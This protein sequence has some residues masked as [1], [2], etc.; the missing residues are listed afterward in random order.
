MPLG[1]VTSYSTDCGM[2][3]RLEAFTVTTCPSADTSMRSR[4]ECS[5]CS[6]TSLRSQAR[7]AISPPKLLISSRLPGRTAKV[8]SVCCRAA[9]AARARVGTNI[10]LLLDPLRDAARLAQQLDFAPHRFGEMVIQVRV[11]GILRQ[12]PAR[13]RDGRVDRRETVLEHPDGQAV[14]PPG[15]LA[16]VQRALQL[17]DGAVVRRIDRAHP[18]HAA[19]PGLRDELAAARRGGAAQGEPRATRREH[20]QRDPRGEQLRHGEREPA[21]AR[22]DGDDPDPPGDGGPEVGPGGPVLERSGAGDDLPELVQGRAALGAIR[23]VRGER[24]ALGGG[25]RLVQV[26]RQTGSPVV[27]H[28]A[29][30]PFFN[31][32]ASAAPCARGAAAISTSR[33]RCPAASRSPR[34]GTPRRRA[35]GTPAWRRRGG[36][37]SPARSPRPSPACPSVRRARRAR[38]GRSPV[39]RAPGPAPCGGRGPGSRRA[40]AATFRTPPHRGTSPA[41]ATRGR[42]RPASGH[43]PDPRPSCAGTDCESGPDESGTAARTHARRRSPRGRRPLLPTRPPPM[44]DP[45]AV[46]PPRGSCTRLDRWPR[47]KVVKDLDPDALQ[48]AEIIGLVGV[49]VAVVD[50]RWNAPRH[51]LQQNRHFNYNRNCDGQRYVV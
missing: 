41:S 31:P 24:L 12:R 22:R 10:S 32:G 25:Q 4:L 40:G 49:L 8:V 26:L 34:A 44:L 11:A 15:A 3:R 21:A 46:S 17:G 16:L 13:L 36:G 35:A 20:G 37:R 23:Q 28:R 27:A 30:P 33:R 5:A 29:T 47:S 18:P 19:G 50:P 39:A 9:R 2:P 43:P 42:T 38:P 1:T 51:Q 14:E 6:R 48:A 45:C 7:T